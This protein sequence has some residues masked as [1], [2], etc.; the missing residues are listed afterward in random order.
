VADAERAAS[1]RVDRGDVGG[2]V[3]GQDALD[4]DAVAA[5]ERDRAAQEADRGGGFFVGEHFGVGQSGG[6]VDGDVHEV[7][8]SFATDAPGGVGVGAG[9]VLAGAGDAFA[10]AA[11]DPPEFLDVDVDQLARP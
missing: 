7:P 11:D 5:V 4:V 8:A 2:A 3:V 9:V 10:G 1:E 6:V